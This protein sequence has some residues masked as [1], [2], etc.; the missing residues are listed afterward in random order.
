MTT[1]LDGTYLELVQASQP[2]TYRGIRINCSDLT[3]SSAFYVAA[4]QL[5]GDDPRQVTRGSQRFEAQRLYL[6]RQRE[7]FSIEL[8]QW[9]EPTPVGTPYATGNHA[10]IYR[11]AAA[12]D[13][14]T[15]SYADLVKAVPSA[16][17][18]VDVD[19]GDDMVVIP[20]AFFPDPDGSIVEL[21][22]RGLPR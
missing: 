11:L 20:A 13:D 4:L 8:T 21:L 5:E 7:T 16:P 17:P 3:T 19:L 2:P 15:V 14:M 10:G 18:P 22:Q 9:E 1:D 6:P 12:V